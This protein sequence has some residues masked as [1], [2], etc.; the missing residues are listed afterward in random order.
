[1]ILK[2]E[3]HNVSGR[4]DTKNR[5]TQCIY[6]SGRI[7]RNDRTTPHMEVA[8]YLVKIE[9]HME[10]AVYNDTKNRTSGSTI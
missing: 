1:M 10:V 8:V 5:T 3:L 6:I 4:N 9:L 7:F 2:I